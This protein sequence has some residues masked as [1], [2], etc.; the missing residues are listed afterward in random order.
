MPPNVQW[1]VCDVPAVI[2]AGREFARTRPALGPVVC[3]YR[4]QN[5]KEFLPP[6]QRWA[7]A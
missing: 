6:W 1:T 7:I 5:R 3:P 2:E 4:V